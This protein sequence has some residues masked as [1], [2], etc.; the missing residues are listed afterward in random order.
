MTTPHLYMKIKW[1]I[2]HKESNSNISDLVHSNDSTTGF[3]EYRK[4][5]HA[6]MQ[7][8]DPFTTSRMGLTIDRRSQSE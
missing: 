4:H 2:Q 5:S 1:L 3:S 8:A 6:F 7:I